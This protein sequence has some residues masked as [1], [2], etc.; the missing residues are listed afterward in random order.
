MSPS[1]LRIILASDPERHVRA[2]VDFLGAQWAGEVAFS[3]PLDD[4]WPL[5]DD[6]V[7][8]IEAETPEAVR[9][10]GDRLHQK[11]IPG[12][13][14]AQGTPADSGRDGVM[15]LPAHTPAELL[16]VRLEA[17][18]HRQSLVASMSRELRICDVAQAGATIEMNRLHEELSLASTIQRQFIPRSIEPIG[19]LAFGSLFR[20]TGYVSGDI[21]DVRPADDEHHAF[22]LADVVGH[23]VPAALL[24]MVVSRALVTRERT[25]LGWHA[26][27]PSTA[28]ARVN[29]EL[30][31]HPEGPHRFAT[32]VYGLISHRTGV[33]TLAG[34]G[35][36]PPL[37]LGVGASRKIETEGP[38]L[39]VF[40]EA[41]FPEVTFTLAP[42]ESLVVHS[43]GMEVAF[44]KEGAAGR[45][46]R[47]P[48][49]RYLEELAALWDAEGGGADEQARLEHAFAALAKRLDDQAG[50]LH[51]PDDV[52]VLAMTRLMKHVARI[53]A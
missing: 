43:D 32:A 44:P 16:A 9:T 4:H 22:F 49:A 39:G 34:A 52:T 47:L 5:S 17:L 7:V 19:S 8:L 6:G 26:C 29:R 2:T 12:V 45:E 37:V 13:I 46:L 35:H 3:T 51:Q 15:V 50:S 36:P 1:R 21:F 33:V 20:P 11:Q 30:C 25:P 28:L 23:G 41:E 24:T 10:L 38:M 27:S 31:Q 48:T 40:D 18:A 14:L 53:A 42:G